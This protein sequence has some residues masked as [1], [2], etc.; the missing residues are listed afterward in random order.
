MLTSTARSGDQDREPARDEPARTGAMTVTA[1]WEHGGVVTRPAAPLPAGQSALLV[2]R[3]QRRARLRR[4]VLTV[5]V[6]GVALVAA[7]IWAGAH[8][9]AWP[10]RPGG[11]VWPGLAVG[12]ATFALVSWPRR[13][14]DRWA[15]G[16]AGEQATA[17]LLARLAPSR[18]TVLHDLAVPGSRANIDHLVIGPTGLWVVDTKAFRGRVEAHGGGVRVG[19]VPLS[20][21]AVR[22]EAEVVSDRLAVPARPIVALHGRGLP[23]RARR[24]QGVSVVAAA[25]LTRRLRRGAL[26]RPTLSA[27]RVK[28]I[29]SLA[30]RQFGRAGD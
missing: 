27:G 18:W 6:A 12:S 4:L 13:D 9:G 29:S 2:W 22:W 21:A 16:A 10:E 8:F 15:R 3:R 19:G 30:E 20:T 23:R 11:W 14:P 28:E 26:L 7:T 25:R 5:V 24:C 17:A 1:A